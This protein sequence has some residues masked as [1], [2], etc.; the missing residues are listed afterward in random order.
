M[1]KESLS[2]LDKR[3]NTRIKRHFLK[4]PSVLWISGR[5]KQVPKTSG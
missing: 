4:A 1:D 5:S 3:T 2:I